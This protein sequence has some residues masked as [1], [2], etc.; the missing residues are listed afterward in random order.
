MYLVFK[1]IIFLYRVSFRGG[2]ANSEIL[3]WDLHPKK[4]GTN[5]TLQKPQV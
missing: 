2:K 5:F 1:M 3:D 4:P